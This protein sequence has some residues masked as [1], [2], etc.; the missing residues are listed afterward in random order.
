MKC[1]RCKRTLKDAL[2]IELGIGPVCRKNP[3]TK[4][5]DPRTFD[6]FEENHCDFDFELM[7]NLVIIRDLNKGNRSVTNDIEHVLNKIKNEVANI[8][9]KAI[10]YKDSDGIFDLV[11][12]NADGTFLN[13]QSLNLKDANRI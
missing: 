2:S 7:G 11:K 5:R 10:I 9:N 6:M 12:T 13:F 1:S 8:G 3:K 4:K